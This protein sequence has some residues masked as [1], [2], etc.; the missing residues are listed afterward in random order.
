[1]TNVTTDITG[2]PYAKLSELKPGD[3]LEADDGF[4]CLR[5]GD[6]M[7]VTKD[8]DGSLYVPCADGGHNLDGQADDGEH[9]IGLYRVAAIGDKIGK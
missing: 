2:R 8:H 5:D 1:M 7:T 4:T 9:L 6:R 3:Q